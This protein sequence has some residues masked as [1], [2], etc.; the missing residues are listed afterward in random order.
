MEHAI[1]FCKIDQPYGCFSNFSP[2]V[3]FVDGTTWKSAEHFFQANKFIDNTVH[4]AIQ[5]A[6][7]PKIAAQIG[8][9][10]SNTLRADWE[11]G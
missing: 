5:M 2:H 11:E 9:D 1:L 10:R 3:V 6:R 7:S 8:R 4:I